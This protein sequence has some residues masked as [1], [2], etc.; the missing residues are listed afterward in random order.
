MAGNSFQWAVAEADLKLNEPLNTHIMIKI[1][2]TDDEPY[3]AGG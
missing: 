2:I 3:G 1:L